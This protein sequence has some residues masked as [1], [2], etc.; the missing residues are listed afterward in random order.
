M[1]AGWPSTGIVASVFAAR[2]ATMTSSEI[3]STYGCGFL[4]RVSGAKARAPTAIETD[5]MGARGEDTRAG[6]VFIHPLKLAR[7]PPATL[8]VGRIAENHVCICE[9]GVS[10]LHARMNVSSEGDFFIE[11]ANSS[12]GTRVHGMRLTPGQQL[13]LAN[14][15]LIEI[16]SVALL[17]VD[18]TMIARLTEE[19]TSRSLYT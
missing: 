6:D 19:V 4:V 8:T 10:R 2:I 16:A 11:D 7:E 15:D 14:R 12:N 5:P 3:A 9:R 18:H 17:F 1:E 13:L